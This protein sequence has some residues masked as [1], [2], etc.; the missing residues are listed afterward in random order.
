M[1][2]SVRK[3]VQVSI[4]V[5][6]SVATAISQQQQPPSN[7]GKPIKIDPAYQKL[8]DQTGGQ[9]YVLDRNNAEQLG[10]VLALNT[11]SNKQELLSVHGPIAGERTYRAPLNSG[12]RQLV[13]SA[14]GVA[15]VQVTA[16]SG[17]I[18]G[19]ANPG[20]RYVALGNGG[21]YAVEN[22]EPGT[23]AVVVRGNGNFSLTITAIPDKSTGANENATESARPDDVDFNSF[24]FQEVAGRPGHQGLF[25]IPGFPVAGH[26]YSVE[27]R[28]SGQYSTVGFQ[29]RSP[30]G[31]V[32]QKIQL[33]KRH[34]EGEDDRT[35]EG[36]VNVPNE[37]FQVYATGLDMRGYRFQRVQSKVI[38]PQ[39]FTVSTS[40]YAEWK[41]GEQNTCT[42]V[43]RNFGP[44]DTFK[45]MIVDVKTYLSSS[46]KILFDLGTDETKE[47]T[48]TFDVPH[49]ATS[50]TLVITVARVA[51]PEASNHAVIEPMIM[52][53]RE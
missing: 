25:K 33:A 31:E 45:A 39:L 15:S 9:V 27:A 41:A 38:R 21:I 5:L 52:A 6:F 42:V 35:Y 12:N 53:R 43:V 8:A 2:S 17:G 23:W 40:R 13:V 19:A 36:E 18:I 11:Y 32:I 44:A 24:E 30:R 37:P 50:D 48:F 22:P 16:P 51:D 47:L 10:A 1:A 20:V 49:E 14:T 29:F 3:F 34:G 46:K 26:T 4:A 28:M 7:S